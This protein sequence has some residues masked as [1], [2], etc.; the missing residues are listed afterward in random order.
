MHSVNINESAGVEQHQ[1]KQCS[2]RA[3]KVKA[4]LQVALPAWSVVGWWWGPSPTLTHSFSRPAWHAAMHSKPW[5]PLV[6]R[7]RE[8]WPAMSSAMLLCS[9]LASC[10]E[11]SARG[12]GAWGCCAVPAATAA[13]GS[14]LITPF[15]MAAGAGRRHAAAAAPAAAIMIYA[16]SCR[17]TGELSSVN[18]CF[19]PTEPYAL[20]DCAYSISACAG[21]SWCHSRLSHCFPTLCPP[22]CRLARPEGTCTCAFTV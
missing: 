9:S 20:I 12:E 14:N 8:Q 1:L 13:T 16:C 22:A 18:L 7:W 4:P 10:P 17:R 3:S 6:S 15:G 11:S 2:Q 21:L 5:L 19:T